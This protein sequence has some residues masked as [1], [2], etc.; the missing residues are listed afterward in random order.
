MSGAE[1]SWREKRPA[2]TNLEW[3]ARVEQEEQ[4]RLRHNGPLVTPEAENHAEY[5]DEFV[6]HI[7]TFTLARTK[8]NMATSPFA[9]LFFRGV[10]DKDQYGASVEIT[11]A[12]EI[13]TRATGML[14][15]NFEPRVDSSASAHDAILEQVAQ[16]RLSVAYTKWRNMLPMPKRMI[17]DMILE[18]G[19]LKA[20]ARKY[21]LGWPR[22]RKLL[23]DALD[24]WIKVREDVARDI[25]DRDV[26]W[27]RLRVEQ[28]TVSRGC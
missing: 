3:R 1:E 16:V 19:S 15:S 2:E 22:A 5:K 28:S 17:L 11:A 24:N 25:D 10:I 7:E 23:I 18:Q 4:L 6:L 27:A 21:R 26:E 9:D 14:A 12:A 20:K 8:R 13:L